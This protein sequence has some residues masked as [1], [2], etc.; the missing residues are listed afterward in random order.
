MREFK[1]LLRVII[2][3]LVVLVTGTIGYIIIEKWSLIDSFFMTVITISTVGYSAVHP[4][5]NA[6]KIFSAFLIVSGVGIALYAFT[7]LID[8]FVKGQI[9][10]IFGRRRMEDEVQKMRNHYILCGYDSIGRVVANSLRSEG[11]PFVILTADRDEEFNAQEKECLCLRADPSDYETLKKA[12]I[13]RAAGLLA[14]TGDDATNVF[15]IVSARKLRSDLFIVARASTQDSVS[16]LEAAGA[17][18]AIS[19][20][21]SGGERIARIALYPGVTEFIERVLPGYGNELSLEEIEVSSG[22]AL[23]G[24]NVREA[25]EFSRGASIL[26]IRKKGIETI[27]KPSDE[28]YIESGDFLII[29]GHREQLRLL[30]TTTQD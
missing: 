3:L 2:P 5:S 1:N 26:A 8:Y 12:G 21:S 4:L 28:T 6:G 9:S 11:K 18:R 23:V 22:S 15:I 7:Y 19:P 16:K 30:E 25:Q 10:N 13:E 24:K 14:V 20:Y 27:A 17:N 29:L